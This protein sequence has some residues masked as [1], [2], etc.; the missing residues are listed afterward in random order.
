MTTSPEHDWCARV[1]ATLEREHERQA[2]R[3]D[4]TLTMKALSL[5][6]DASRAEDADPVTRARA[7]LAIYEHRLEDAQTDDDGNPLPSS[8]DATRA[9]AARI[10][11]RFIRHA[12]LNL[13]ACLQVDLLADLDANDDAG[14]TLLALANLWARAPWAARRALL[15]KACALDDPRLLPA[16]ARAFSSLDVN[17]KLIVT[18][19]CD[20]LD[21]LATEPILCAALLTPD[22]TLATLAARTLSRTGTPAA[23]RD[24]H[25]ARSV[26]P[27]SILPDLDRAT[28]LILERHPVHSSSGDLSYVDAPEGQISLYNDVLDASSAG[29]PDPYDVRGA[30]TR[31]SQWKALPLAPRRVPLT[32]RLGLATHGTNPLH[33][34]VF[35]LAYPLIIGFSTLPDIALPGAIAAALAPLLLG[36][37]FTR[38]AVHMLSRGTPAL[39]LVTPEADTDRLVLEYLSDTGALRT[40]T[41]HQNALGT[42]GDERLEPVLFSG[43]DDLALNE[44][45][46]VDLREGRL[47]PSPRGARLTLAILA[48]HLLLCAWFIGTLIL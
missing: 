10:L 12:P 22:L 44:L 4:L 5:L 1:D 17:S 38:H 14:P 9:R 45:L 32:V 3:G 26:H 43:D 42:L 13:R 47:A 33:P 8:R 31:A 46:H 7:A 18:R 6:I 16:Y 23:L 28:E 19:A 15:S 41:V 21:D 11:A 48:G 40:R 39:A 30:L 24:I 20:R 25:S 34:F 29:L 35:P 27:A 2:R 36:A 37:T